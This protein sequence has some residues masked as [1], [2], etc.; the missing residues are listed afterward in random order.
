VTGYNDMAF[1][2]RFDPPLT[3]VRIAHRLMGEEAARLL[4]AEIEDTA[5]PRQRIRLAPVLV[6]RGS[7]APPPGSRRK[8]A[9]V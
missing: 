9:T 4:L 5:L 8:H 2:D 3:S 6:V 7:T 1:A